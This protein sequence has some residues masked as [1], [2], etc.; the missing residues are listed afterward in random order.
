MTKKEDAFELYKLGWS[1]K[2][3]AECLKTS[4]QNLTRWK[5]EDKWNDRLAHEANNLQAFETDI[6]ELLTFESAVL[7]AKIEE[8]KRLID[9]G[10]T[11]LHQAPTLDKGSVDTLS[12]L[13]KQVRQKDIEWATMINVCCDFI[14]SIDKEDNELA[15]TLL[16]Y[17]DAFINDNKSKGND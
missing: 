10:E 11:K 4:E 9:A 13:Y 6:W 3:I 15:K 5:K 2:R 1:Q 7:K 17:L 8:C 16:P 14:D 12:K